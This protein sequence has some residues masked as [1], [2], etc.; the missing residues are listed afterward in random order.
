MEKQGIE[1]KN[2]IC[3][4]YR[5]YYKSRADNTTKEYKIL[6]GLEKKTWRQCD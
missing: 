4:P 3:G 1:R 2:P 5:H 6:K